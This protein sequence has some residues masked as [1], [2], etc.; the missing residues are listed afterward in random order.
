MKICLIKPIDCFSVFQPSSS[1]FFVSPPFS[2]STTYVLT[3]H[4]LF[5]YVVTYHAFHVCLSVPSVSLILLCFNCPY[6]ICIVLICYLSFYILFKFFPSLHPA[7][8]HKAQ[9]YS[10][11]FAFYFLFNYQNSERYTTSH[12]R[13]KF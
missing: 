6:F 9:F 13:I 3:I 4:C 7:V 2:A 1:N 12:H 10:L 11:D 8:L 5:R